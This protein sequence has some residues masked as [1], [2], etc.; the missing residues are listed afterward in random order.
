[1]ICTG[2]SKR[3]VAWVTAGCSN[4]WE[5]P[6]IEIAAS[7]PLVQ[8]IK[9][10]AARLRSHSDIPSFSRKSQALRAAVLSVRVWKSVART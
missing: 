10:F 9:R 6:E 4:F 2:V 1:M 5:E 8:K 3:F 7:L